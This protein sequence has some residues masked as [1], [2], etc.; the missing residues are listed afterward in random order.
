MAEKLI[1]LPPAK[2]KGAELTDIPDFIRGGVFDS[3]STEAM[4]RAFEFVCKAKPK[5]SR[6][7]I[8]NRIIELAKAGERDAAKLSEKV[9]SELTA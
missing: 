8:A 9:I 4:G 6:E 5:A 7:L 1:A 2:T 3:D